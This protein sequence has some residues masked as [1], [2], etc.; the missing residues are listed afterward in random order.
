MGQV[1]AELERQ[2]I[3]ATTA[4]VSDGG[5]LASTEL[6]IKKLSYQREQQKQAINESAPVHVLAEDQVETSPQTKVLP[7]SSLINTHSCSS[8]DSGI[9][10]NKTAI[11]S[12]STTPCDS[13]QLSIINSEILLPSSHPYT[14]E[15]AK[16]SKWKGKL[17]ARSQIQPELQNQ[18]LLI[19]SCSS[20]SS[21]ESYSY[22]GTSIS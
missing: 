1:H 21:D 18:T 14:T 15:I 4:F 19:E 17:L 6:P 12:K 5:L 9:S 2:P 8:M 10:D 20:K 22:P 11:S 7:G 13:K 16:R 3:P